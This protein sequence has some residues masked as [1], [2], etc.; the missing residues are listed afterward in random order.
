[1][2]LVPT[3]D[4]QINFVSFFFI[5]QPLI[6]RS[7]QKEAD[8]NHGFYWNLSFF[9]IGLFHVHRMGV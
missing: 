8:A 5:R 6:K 9:T 2:P 3:S 4:L 7:T 1:M